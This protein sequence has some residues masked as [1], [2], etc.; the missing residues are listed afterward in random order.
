M[1]QTKTRA[2]HGR[3]DSDSAQTSVPLATPAQKWD[4]IYRGSINILSS[5]HSGEGTEEET[6]AGGAQN[7]SETLRHHKTDT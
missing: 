5:P 2:A 4:D 7:G 3:R 1:S 6:Q